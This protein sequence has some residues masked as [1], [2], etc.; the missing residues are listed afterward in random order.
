MG[1]RLVAVDVE[2]FDPDIQKHGDGSCADVTD[3]FGGR[4]TL[5]CVGTYDGHTA[6]A[7]YPG[8]P[9]WDEFRAMMSDGT[10][11][12]VFHNGIYDLS[13]LC[14]RYGIEAKGLMHDTMTRMSYI[15]EY[16]DLDLD[17]CCKRFGVAGK[18]KGE[19]IEAWWDMHGPDII[20]MLKAA[21][22]PAKKNDKLW[23]HS[24]YL[25]DN[26]VEFREA[27]VSYN[28]QDCRATYSLYWAQEPKMRR[29]RGAYMVDTKLVPL[30]IDMK[31]DGVLIDRKRLAELT[32]EVESDLSIWT[33]KL[34]DVYGIMPEMILSPKQLGKRL[35]DMGIHSPVKTA[36]GS[37]SFSSL[38]LDRI[39]HPVVTDIQNW[40]VLNSLLTK[41]LRGS[42]ANSILHDGR[43]HCTFTPNKRED[44]GTV[45]GRFACKTPNL[46]NIPQR[47]KSKDKDIKD[48]HY[49]QAMRSLFLPE[50]SCVMGA[51]DYSQI[52]YLL[53]AH[54]AVGN[55]AEWFREQANAGVDFHTVAMQ[56]TG[57]PERNIVKTFNYGVIYGMGWRKAL[58][59]NYSMFEAM[60][61]A[62]GV[63]LED[64]VHNVYNDYHSRLP[65]IRETM[66][67]VENIARLQG[68]VITLGGRLQHK[69]KAVYDAATGRT[70]D[71]IYKMLNKLIQGSAADILK[72][73]LLDCY[74]AGLFNTLKMHLTVHDENVVSIPYNKEGTEAAKELK[75]IM[76][77]SFHDVLK[78]PM[79]AAAEVGPDW[80]YWDH[81][82]WDDMCA[83]KFDRAKECWWAA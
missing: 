61:K 55:Q 71:F 81:D 8:A 27:M 74:E 40:K 69:P 57:I 14:C 73:A 37:E 38:A 33:R 12:K 36:T 49:G 23:Q 17:T 26:Y 19:T 48:K 1:N 68:Y 42:M 13:W 35:N 11:D 50:H 16:A 82:I 62:K 75:R 10:V 46:Q 44:G 80:G 5:L 20:P 65:V 25:F 31:R 78:V 24:K 54:F 77:A 47:E 4:S 39:H 58:D 2:T 66:K 56:A 28:L 34:E 53:L 63:G 18:N 67:T 21:G 45:T 64:F 52:E 72:Y 6:K 79:K 41:Y 22:V 59:M 51:F 3:E 32:D 60:A 30:I 76:E 29:V 15:D 43:I 83:G 70:Q 9:G 7:Y